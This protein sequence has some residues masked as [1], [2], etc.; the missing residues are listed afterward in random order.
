MKKLFLIAGLL[1]AQTWISFAEK[2]T[3]NKNNWIKLDWMVRG[4]VPFKKDLHSPDIN[5]KRWGDKVFIALAGNYS[6]QDSIELDKVIQSYNNAIPNLEIQWGQRGKSNLTIFLTN[7]YASGEYSMKY[8]INYNIYKN[9]TYNRESR[10][11]NHEFRFI[12]IFDA[13]LYVHDEPEIEKRKI[14]LWNA[15]GKTLVD[16]GKNS[17]FRIDKLSVLGGELSYLTDFDMFFFSTI[18]SDS[19]KNQYLKFIKSE[20]NFWEEYKYL[21]DD[22]TKSTLNLSIYIIVSLILIYFSYRF[23]WIKRLDHK[24]KNKFARYQFIG[25]LFFVPQILCSLFYFV[26]TSLKFQHFKA[27]FLSVLIVGIT[28]F[29]LLIFIYLIFSFLCYFIEH[30]LFNWVKEFKTRQII[31]SF[32][33]LVCCSLF[34]SV[35]AFNENISSS[36]PIRVQSFNILL[37]FLLIVLGRLFFFYDQQQKSTIQKNQQLKIDKLEQLQTKL[38]LDAIQAKTNPHFLYNSLNTIASLACQDAKKTEEF[39]LKLA[40]LLR[41]R[42]Q[43]NQSA[44]IPLED[45]IETIQLYLEIE[46]ERFH[47]RLKY[48]IETP[49]SSKK[50]LIPSNVILFLIENSVKH[51]ISQQTGNG[52]IKIAI[53]EDSEHLKIMVSDNGPNFP[54]KPI[55]GTGLKSLME[56]LDILYPGA[57]EFVIFNH[58]EKRTEI[59]LNKQL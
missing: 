28:A 39:A 34:L 27:N 2:Q 13:N 31:R 43:D 5:I 51:G 52:M 7:L 29:V 18:Y 26:P 55:Y 24:I 9:A 33:I 19:F 14:I 12:E 46:K 41:L 23:I 56:K 38:Q 20:Y 36:I 48:S 1:I 57:Y 54:D 21:T 50:I 44:E 16:I 42:L 53:K 58:P 11:L 47:D 49:D 15:F 25:L 40:Q 6:K 8:A 17:G 32:S 37:S 10:F 59:T 30:V 3:E 22:S 35:F 45:E 4:T